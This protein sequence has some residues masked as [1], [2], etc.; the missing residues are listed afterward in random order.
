MDDEP[1][2][3]RLEEELRELAAHREPVPPELL[4]AAVAAFGW[5]D[6]DAE[7]AELV[8][9]SLAETSGAAAVRGSAGQ[10]L[11][12]FRAGEVAIDVEVAPGGGG[13]HVLGQI[14]PPRAAR[15]ELRQQRDVATV[16][17]DELGR[18][19]YGPLDP[20]PLSLRL[21]PGPGAGQQA[22]TTDWVTI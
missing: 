6:I 14:M 12:S 3:N 10:R 13:L 16:T 4:A 22:V 1:E 9:D 19:E 5:R 7:L 17:A 20:G 15:V 2:I 21:H 18:F 8:Y 11:V